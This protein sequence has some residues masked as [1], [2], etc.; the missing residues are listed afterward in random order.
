MKAFL[1]ELQQ[2]NHIVEIAAAAKNPGFLQSPVRGTAG[3]RP[4]CVNLA[5]GHIFDKNL[6]LIH[7]LCEYWR[8]IVPIR[9]PLSQMISRK[10]RKGDENL[11]RQV[12]TWCR[13]F[14]E[15][16][17][18]DPLYIPLDLLRDPLSRS[19]ALEGV[20]QGANL[21]FSKNG[22][23]LCAKWGKMWPKDEHNSRGTYPNKIAYAN[24]DF[25]H[26][27][28]VMG[29]SIEHLQGQEFFLR[30]HLEGIGYRNL[31]WWT[32][33]ETPELEGMTA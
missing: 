3:F 10:E 33:P 25:N 8:P 29:Q 27:M 32:G 14:H 22:P 4:D 11:Q 12:E 9:D 21:Q 6:S 23:E 28:K 16:A 31:M 26:L 17:Q 13:L 24:G 20:V 7:A 5:Y 19:Q 15:F 1:I 2:V 18:Y 30:P